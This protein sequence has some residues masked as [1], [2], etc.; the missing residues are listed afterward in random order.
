[1]EQPKRTKEQIKADLKAAGYGN[2]GAWVVGILLI[3]ALVFGIGF[4]FRYKDIRKG[5]SYEYV[6][7][8]VIKSYTTSTTIGRRTNSD[9]HIVVR[10]RPKGSD[11]DYTASVDDT[12]NF[13]GGELRVYYKKDI[14]EDGYVAR[15]DLLTGQYIP[16][17]KNYDV[18]VAITGILLL[19]A[20]YLF[21]DSVRAKSRAKKGTLKIKKPV[22]GEPVYAD[23]NL[24]E[25]ARMANHKRS[26]AGAW[27]GFGMLYALFMAMGISW[28][29]ISLKNPAK[30][31][32]FL[33]PGII[34]LFIAQGCP[35]TIFLT[36]RRLSARKKNFIKAF[37]AD[38]ITA[39]YADRKN[40][41][42]KLWKYVKRFMESETIGSKY[43]LE[44]QRYWVEKYKDYLER[45]R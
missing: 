35:L 9:H 31:G 11:K 29:V 7:G 36:A 16:D 40:A 1:M 42:K 28:V 27:F 26:W 30:D 38:E 3:A 15:K 45:F 4:Y 18:P 41:A 14:P 33:I 13:F 39:V 2:Q 12:W 34:V 32:S 8:T 25:M 19:C 44:Y 43:R 20:L 6:K 37:M 21:I 22:P 23:P 17:G 24:H 5:D 10:Y